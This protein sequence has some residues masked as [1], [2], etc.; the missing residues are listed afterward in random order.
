MN[1]EQ[2]KRNTKREYLMS[3]R[4][5]CNKCGYTFV[6]MTRREKHRYY[7][8]NGAWR[9]PK[10]CDTPHFRVQDVDDAIWNWVKGLLESPENLA[11]GLQGMQEESM[12]A[13]QSLYD[14]LIMIEDQITETERQLEKLL[15]LYL[16]E[17]FPKEM[18][19]ER[20]TNLDTTLSNLKREKAD[21]A[22]HLQTTTV[23]IEQIAGIEAFCAKIREGLDIATFEQKRQ[24]IDMLDVR[25]KL[26]IENDEKVVYVKC[27]LG[28]QLLSVAR[29]SPLSSTGVTATHTCACPLMAPSL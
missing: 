13:N 6:G 20:K 10:V 3:R 8:C 12:R 29:T 4:L 22:S 9:T 24:V 15:D 14:R 17:N 11:E 25:G 2:S 23:T 19:Q 1:I 16:N 7:R 21:L 18:L 5:R 26:A 28:Q 27:I